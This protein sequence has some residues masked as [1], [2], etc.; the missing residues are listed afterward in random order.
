M[1]TQINGT[2]IP[3][4]PPELAEKGWQLFLT[5]TARFKAVNTKL[6]IEEGSGPYPAADEAIGAARDL[7]VEIEEEKAVREEAQESAGENADRLEAEHVAAVARSREEAGGHEWRK[8]SL[9]GER[10]GFDKYRCELCG[11]TAKRYGVSW[12]PVPDGKSAFACPKAARSGKSEV[13]E[14]IL[15]VDLVAA[16]WTIEWSKSSEGVEW[17]LSNETLDLETEWHEKSADA[18][19]QAQEL[20]RAAEANR[21]ENG[22]L[23]PEDMLVS[24]WH[25]VFDK[26]PNCK[27]PYTAK[28]DLLGLVTPTYRYAPDALARARELEAEH[29]A[30]AEA[31]ANATIEEAKQSEGAARAAAVHNAI[32]DAERPVPPRETRQ[33]RPTVLKLIPT[34]SINPEVALSMRAAGLDLLKVAEYKEA[35]LDGAKFP[36]VDVFHDSETG[37]NHLAGGAHRHASAGLEI[38]A[39]VHDG[40]KRDAIIFAATENATHGLPRTNEDKRLAVT[41]LLT[42]EEWVVNADMVIAKHAGVTQPFVGSVRSDLELKNVIS[43]QPR[44]RGTDGVMRD[45][46]KI[47]TQH[48]KRAD[49]DAAGEADNRQTTLA[50]IG[51]DLPPRFPE[52]GEA[53][54]GQRET[55]PGEGAREVTVCRVCQCTDESPCE[56]GCS[57]VRPG[58]DVCSAC[59][60]K[61][62]GQPSTVDGQPGAEFGS[63]PLDIVQ[64]MNRHA[65]VLYRMQ[66]E[67]MGFSHEAILKAVS[68]GAILQPETGKFTLP[69]HQPQP[70]GGEHRS[71]DRSQRSES[72]VSTASG[73]PAKPKQKIEEILKG[74]M[75]TISFTWIPKVPG[76]SVSVKAG[77]PEDAERGMIPSDDMP[78]FP[79]SIIAMITRQLS[80]AKAPPA[81]SKKP[82]AAPKKRPS[83]AQAALNKHKARKAAAKKKP[84]K[85]PVKKAAKAR[86]R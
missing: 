25:L 52:A 3:G 21:A 79:E 20:T 14:P 24:G 50:D 48:E 36:P 76:A 30:A 26:D 11:A 72:T 53:E 38:F 73:P 54:E 16:G 19:A 15:P 70:S 4:M 17:Q 40:T 34:A 85:K 41:A 44:R 6:G 7:Q 65:G 71:E 49:A 68:E 62:A 2:A 74:R 42:D 61:A 69:D 80:G 81:A 8:T 39:N 33:P 59:L 13:T 47:G 29:D 18:F 78:R 46:T 5:D 75:L 37:E 55:G 58:D 27:L 57:W 31:K 35:R 9:F 66:L 43:P 22:S 10:G 28:S 32:I 60:A 82:A 12:P 1:S 63:E 84:T 86:K 45:T 64:V 77:K 67:E 83:A 23:T 56:E 51:V